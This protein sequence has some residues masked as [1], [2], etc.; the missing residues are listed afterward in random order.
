MAGV[1]ISLAVT[2]LIISEM[3]VEAFGVFALALSVSFLGGYASLTDL[4]VEAATARFI[5]EARS[6]DDIE[7]VNSAAASSMA[8][9]GAIAVVAAPLLMLLAWPLTNLFGIEGELRESARVCF[10]YMGLQ[11]VFELPARAFFAVLE[12][13]QRFTLWQAVELTRSVAQAIGWV[14]VIALGGSV[15]ELGA[16]MAGS[17]LLV[18]LLGFALAKRAVPGL[19][20]SPLR[21]SRAALKPLL[22]FGGGMFVIRLTGTLYRQMDKAIVGAAMGVKSVA[23]YEIANRIHAGAAMIQSVAA[24]AIVPAA[25]YVREQRDMLR[26]MYLRGTNHAVAASLPFAIGAMILAEPLVR[27]WVGDDLVS[28]ASSARLFLV[29]LIFTAL[30]IVGA[31][32]VTALG[33]L[34]PVMVIAVINLAVNAVVSLA[35]VGPYGVDGVIIGTLVGQF[36]AFVPLQRLIFREFDVGLAEW[37]RVVLAP[38][39]PGIAAQLLTAYPLLLVARETSNVIESG[40][41]LLVSIG[42]SYVAF[43]TL[44]LS[45]ER[46]SQLLGT[47]S[48]AVGRGRPFE[49]HDKEAAIGATGPE[50]VPVAESTITQAA[51]TKDREDHPT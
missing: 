46:R 49:P 44:G 40:S 12:G 16:V 36:A 18:L 11:L 31:T 43:M 15:G 30:L 6:R 29:Y 8:F 23:V 37:W 45:R 48:D 17:S 19:N 38:N 35:L 20:T 34:R 13:A 24:S 2:P 27:T 5:A 10:L 32:M 28:A 7:G 4:G 39:L 1:L 41:L 33:R 25:A 26:D 21:A 42:C 3:G 47:L 51:T 22:S 50:V 14:V 9:F